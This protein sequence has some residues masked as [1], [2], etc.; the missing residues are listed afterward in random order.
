M[1][2]L[3]SLSPR[4]LFFPSFQRKTLDVQGVDYE[5]R[6]RTINVLFTHF[7]TRRNR[8]TRLR[9]SLPGMETG[10]RFASPSSALR[11]LGQF[12]YRHLGAKQPSRTKKLHGSIFTHP[13]MKHK[14]LTRMHTHT[15]R[16]NNFPPSCRKVHRLRQRWK[17]EKGSS[18][19]DRLWLAL[20][21][22]SL[23]R[24][25][26]PEPLSSQSATRCTILQHGQQGP[27]NGVAA[28]RPVAFTLPYSTPVLCG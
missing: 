7:A 26:S 24:G 27:R 23:L 1:F 8:A 4:Q 16:A 10:L 6:Y 25:H 5:I 18:G 2:V 19:S 13:I 22:C 3:S 28:P 14:T 12:R 11:A 21:K 17:G 9:L 20:C 15:R